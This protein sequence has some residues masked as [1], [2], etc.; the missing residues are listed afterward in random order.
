MADGYIAGFEA[1]YHYNYWRPASAVRD[2][3]KADA[4]YPPGTSVRDQGLSERDDYTSLVWLAG[5]AAL[6]K[7]PSG[8]VAM[9]ETGAKS[10]SGS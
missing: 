3:S 7:S 4:A 6:T 9:S 10:L 8:N 5:T 2:A 1:K